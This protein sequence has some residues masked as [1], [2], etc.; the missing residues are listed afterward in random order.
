MFDEY[1]RLI[2][3]RYHLASIT[4]FGADTPWALLRDD[5]VTRAAQI[6]Q[7][8]QVIESGEAEPY[9]DAE[10]MFADINAGR[11]TVS[12]ANSE[13]SLWT[14]EENVA[15]RLVHDVLG[16]GLS[17]GGFDWEGKNRACEIHAR[18]LAPLARRALFTECIAQTAYAI[19]CGEFAEQKTVLL[20]QGFDL[21]KWGVTEKTAAGVCG[22]YA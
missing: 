20:D 8:F 9:A 6:R 2:A 11:I 3:S 21:S 12:R 18:L 4:G 17:G 1:G 15:F 19:F 22:A 14:V 5:S 13:H 7:H 16:H 10:E